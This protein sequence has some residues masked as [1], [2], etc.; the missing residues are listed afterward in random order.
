MSVVSRLLP[1]AVAVSA[2]SCASGVVVLDDPTNQEFVFAEE[3]RIGVGD[4]LSIDV[5]AHED[6]STIVMVR[7]D[8]KITIPIAGDIPVGGNEPEEVATRITKILSTF[9]RD[10]IVT[11]TVAN[12]SNSDYLSRIRI[13]GA[14]VSP[15]S[16]EFK[17]GMTVMDVVLE[18]GGVN[19][20]ANSAKV[21]VFRQGHEPIVIRLD[22]ILNGRDLRSN[23]RLRPGDVITVPERL[24]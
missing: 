19:E 14:V 16:V 21:R 12:V 18:A 7:P 24:F 6:V 23:V 10:P 2:I 20:F 5:Y 15:Q 13:T 17:N 8:G 3:Y 22:R 1:F 4:T 11:V 9:I